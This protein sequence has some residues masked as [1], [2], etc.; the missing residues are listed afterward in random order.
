[1]SGLG[2]RAAAKYI[3]GYRAACSHYAQL[4]NSG[5]KLLSPLCSCL[6][7]RSS[8]GLQHPPGSPHR[9]QSTPLVLP[10]TRQGQEVAVPRARSRHSRN[11]LF[12][13]SL[14]LS[15]HQLMET[16]QSGHAGVCQ[17]W[18]GSASTPG[19]PQP[20]Q[21][22]VCLSVT[23]LSCTPGDKQQR[24]WSPTLPVQQPPTQTCH[25]LLQPCPCHQ[26]PV[27]TPWQG[28]HTPR[29]EHW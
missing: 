15:Q 19:H 21:G 10:G 1:M 24:P 29:A 28:T 3:T 8:P 16:A 12:P 20:A 18:P 17:G 14:L 5:S 25:W 27:T 2:R 7:S 9:A 23:A 4:V 11:R 13:R 26:L 6:S 22:C